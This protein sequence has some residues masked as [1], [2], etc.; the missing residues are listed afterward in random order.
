MGVQL[1][2]HGT[3]SARITGNKSSGV[4][5]VTTTKLPSRPAD[6]SIRGDTLIGHRTLATLVPIQGSAVNTRASYAATSRGC[7]RGINR[8]AEM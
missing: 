1:R 4:P 8:S 7:V 2:G 3:Q 6:G 5:A